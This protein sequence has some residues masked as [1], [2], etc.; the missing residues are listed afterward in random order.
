MTSEACSVGSTDCCK[1]TIASTSRS[2]PRRYT[3]P[4]EGAEAECQVVSRSCGGKLGVA[5]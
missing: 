1:W 5:S 4:L 2:L 3:E